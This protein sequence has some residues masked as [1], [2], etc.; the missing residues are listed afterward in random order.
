MIQNGLLKQDTFPGNVRTTH[1][2][3]S[4]NRMYRNEPQMA[5]R[6]GPENK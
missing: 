4:V 5:P 3:R 2:L 1:A 6:V